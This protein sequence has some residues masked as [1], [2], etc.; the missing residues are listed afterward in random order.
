[1]KVM[2][3]SSFFFPFIRV[4]IANLSRHALLTLLKHQEKAVTM[5]KVA[6]KT[7]LFGDIPR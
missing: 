5:L 4:E 2:L 1:M 6:I 7:S 3:D